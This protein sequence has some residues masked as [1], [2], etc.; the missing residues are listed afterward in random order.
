MDVILVQEV[1]TN[2]SHVTYCHCHV[3]K[4]DQS[5]A[6]A[7]RAEQYDQEYRLYILRHSMFLE[8]LILS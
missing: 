3:E 5:F 2:T 1:L 7:E 4:R 8:H 6:V